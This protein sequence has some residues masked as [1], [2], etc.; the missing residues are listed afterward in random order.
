MEI[1]WR[2]TALDG[3]EH[4]RAYIAEDNP[5]AAEHMRERILAA[6]RNLADMPGLGHPGRIDGTRELVVS[7]TS[8]I[9]AYL[10]THNQLMILAVLHAARQGPEHF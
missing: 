7:D 5:L 6:V 1:I 10:V 9:V 2:E 4:A 3:L 8:Y